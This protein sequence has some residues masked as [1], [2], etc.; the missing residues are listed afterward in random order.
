MEIKNRLNGDVIVSIG[1]A[2]QP[3]PR[4]VSRLHPNFADAARSVG[5]LCKVVSDFPFKDDSDRS[6][7]L[8]MV[9][10][11]AGRHN[12]NNSVPKFLITGG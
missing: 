6:A 9:L 5:D 11:L 8:A 12:I 3:P 1:E 2:S 10:T 4:H 7:W